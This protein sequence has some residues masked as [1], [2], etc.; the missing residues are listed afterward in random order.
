MGDWVAARPEPLLVDYHNITPMAY[1]ARYEPH[2]AA[3]MGLGRRQLQKLGHRATLGLADS[4]YNA[5]ELDELGYRAT[6]VVPIL[7]DVT[8]LDVDARA[9]DAGP[10]SAR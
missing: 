3:V 4:A 2:T 10:G 9:G 6:A 8:T 5:H 1:F 7:L